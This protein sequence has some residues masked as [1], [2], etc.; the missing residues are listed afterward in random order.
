MFKLDKKKHSSLKT[1]MLSALTITACSLSMASLDGLLLKAKADDLSFSAGNSAVFGGASNDADL[2]WGIAFDTHNNVSTNSNIVG[3]KITIMTLPSDLNNQLLNLS[4]RDAKRKFL[5]EHVDSFNLTGTPQS[6]GPS[7]TYQTYYVFCNPC[8]YQTYIYNYSPYAKNTGSENDLNVPGWIKAD[9]ENSTVAIGLYKEASTYSPILNAFG[10][11]DTAYCL[12]GPEIFTVNSDRVSFNKGENELPEDTKQ[13]ICKATENLAKSSSFGLNEH[14]A[15][16]WY[17]EPIMHVDIVAQEKGVQDWVDVAAT[18]MMLGYFKDFVD[19]YNGARPELRL[20]YSGL[21]AG[22]YLDS[23][24]DIVRTN[25]L[26]GNSSASLDKYPT[27]NSETVKVADTDS[28]TVN[29][30][31]KGDY[32]AYA[33]VVLPEDVE[34]LDTLP[35]IPSIPIFTGTSDSISYSGKSASVS[36]NTWDEYISCLSYG[37]N[38]SDTVPS[39]G[40]YSSNGF[41]FDNLRKVSRKIYDED[42]NYTS[43]Y[44]DRYIDSY[45]SSIVY[46]NSTPLFTAEDNKLT[47]SPR[48][49]TNQPESVSSKFGTGSAPIETPTALG[50][51]RDNQFTLLNQV[52]LMW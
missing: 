4:D 34:H 52:P 35:Q 15:A 6:F 16:I 9:S 24:I 13:A 50:G 43:E 21:N 17:V 32:G 8:S 47:Y 37:L 28:V 12:Y 36:K 26:S 10:N 23:M 7:A 11:Y 5:K 31:V 20:S 33:H 41:Y 3:A 19:Y 39:N 25:E 44:I 14:E 38:L 42:N 46:N 29:E 27:L 18:P 22:G 48:N 1:I 40:L 51:I 30:F 45:N 49:S 2:S